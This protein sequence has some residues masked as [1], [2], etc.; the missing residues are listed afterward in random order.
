MTLPYVLLG[1]RICTVFLHVIFTPTSECSAIASDFLNYQLLKNIPDH[2]WLGN[3]PVL[4]RGVGGCGGVHAHSAWAAR[5]QQNATSHTKRRRYIS[6]SELLVGYSI[7][8]PSFFW[9]G[10]ALWEGR[11]TWR[12]KTFVEIPCGCEKLW[13]VIDALYNLIKAFCT[14]Q[15]GCGEL[16]DPSHGKKTWA[17]I[18][19][20]KKV[21]LQKTLGDYL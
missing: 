11:S 20:K 13:E 3:A 7:L 2:S 21:G 16:V 18:K 17:M 15:P 5:A 6:W 1:N 4:S 9:G 12:T 8:L 19:G 10:G 14:Q